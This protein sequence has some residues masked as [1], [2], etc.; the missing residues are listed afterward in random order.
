MRGKKNY[1]SHEKVAMDLKNLL[2]KLNDDDPAAASVLRGKKIPDRF[3]GMRGKKN[4]PTLANDQLNRPPSKFLGM[5]GKKIVF[6][7]GDD[8]VVEEQQ[9]QQYDSEEDSEEF[10][11]H[12]PSDK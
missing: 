9:S 1:G 8:N 12:K 10:D 2:V 6:W 7:T 4:D 5:R 11:S 3:L